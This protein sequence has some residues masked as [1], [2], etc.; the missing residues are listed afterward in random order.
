VRGA[1]DGEGDDQTRSTIRL[2][3]AIDRKLEVELALCR[4]AAGVER[5]DEKKD[6]ERLGDDDWNVGDSV[7]E[8]L[9]AAV[10]VALADSGRCCCSG[11]QR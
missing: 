11:S 1:E 7:R 2:C 8:R 3:K 5:V 6:F 10:D 9:A 4:V